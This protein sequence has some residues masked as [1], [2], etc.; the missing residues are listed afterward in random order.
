MTNSAPK[1]LKAIPGVGQAVESDL[2]HLG[3]YKVDELCGQDAEDLYRRLQELQGPGVDRCMLYVFRCA[4]Y[5]AE[6]G[7]DPELPKWWNWK[8]QTTGE[9]EIPW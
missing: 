3:I 9:R 7:R 6:G 1:G 5:Y 8:E 4:V 2:Q